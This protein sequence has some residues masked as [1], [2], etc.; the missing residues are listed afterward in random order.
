MLFDGT[1]IINRMAK[2]I[3]FEAVTCLID[4]EVEVIDERRKAGRKV[5]S[6]ESRKGETWSSK[7]NVDRL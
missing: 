3:I 6:W 1:W 5:A 4:Q 2:S 7:T